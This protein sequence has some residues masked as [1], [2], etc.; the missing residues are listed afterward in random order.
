MDTARAAAE[1]L[2]VELAAYNIA[3]IGEYLKAD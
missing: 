3:T 2:S 1:S